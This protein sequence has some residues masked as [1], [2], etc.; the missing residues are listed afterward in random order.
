LGIIAYQMLTGAP[1]FTGETSSII[2]AHTENRPASVREFNK[3]L[4][5]RVARAVMHALEKDPHLRPPTAIAFSGSIRANADGLGTL[6]RRAFS[7]YTEYFP[8]FLK[9]SLLAHIPVFV[10]MAMTFAYRVYEPRLST[11]MTIVLGIPLGLLQI[12][13][14]F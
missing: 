1:P 13:V 5:K 8:E 14:K 9:L 2:R 7:L 11:K 4:P 12:V 3:K 10:V 6:Y